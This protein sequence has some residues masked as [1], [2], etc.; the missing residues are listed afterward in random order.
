ML[1]SRTWSALAR[2][3]FSFLPA[4]GTCTNR[5]I[6][7]SRS[8]GVLLRIAL[9]MATPSVSARHPAWISCRACPIAARVGPRRSRC[10]DRNGTTPICTGPC[11]P[12][13]RATPT[14]PGPGLLHGVSGWNPVRAIIRYDSTRT[15]GTLAAACISRTWPM[16][17]GTWATMTLTTL[18]LPL[19]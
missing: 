16:D 7:P 18:R 5:R 6:G 2:H 4:T 3:P 9:R 11:G 13:N 19:A 14:I 17:R 8:S 1:T 10:L 15:P 12:A